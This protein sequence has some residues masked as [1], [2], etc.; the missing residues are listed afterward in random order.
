[1]AYDI[2]DLV[3]I[4]GTF[5]DSANTA[6]DPTTVSITIA[7]PTS[8]ETTY[9]Y[10]TD[11]ALVKDSVGNY[12]ANWSCAE[13]GVHRYRWVSTGTLQAAEEGWFTV[14]PQSF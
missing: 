1:M 10:G 4:S 2:G 9:V 14:R 11:A 12:H 13:S 8:A 3:K 6:G 7:P 5:T